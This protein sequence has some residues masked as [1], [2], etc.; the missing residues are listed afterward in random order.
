MGMLFESCYRWMQL[1]KSLSKVKVYHILIIVSQYTF[2]NNVT[3][4]LIFSL[5]YTQ[6]M[7]KRQGD[8]VV[9][10]SKDGHYACLSMLHNGQI[11][12]R[13]IIKNGDGM[14][15]V[16]FINFELLCQ[17]NSCVCA[18]CRFW[19]QFIFPLL[20]SE[21]FLFDQFSFAYVY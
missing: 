7:L 9:H 4:K 2:L 13:D 15:M 6:H 8:F 10:T 5:I 19:Y 17:L 21:T 12:S 11:V 3:L 1:D 18:I 14:F 20:L 16:F